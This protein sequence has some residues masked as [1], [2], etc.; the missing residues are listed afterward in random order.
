MSEQSPI[1]VEAP[2][3]IV[4]NSETEG[5]HNDEHSSSSASGDG[6]PGSEEGS[7]SGDGSAQS[8]GDGILE[9]GSEQI[10][11]AAIEAER[12][13]ALAEIHSDVERERIELERD[14]LETRNEDIAE[15]RREVERLTALVDSLMETVNLLTPPPILELVTEELPTVP[16][17]D[18][19]QPS[20]AAPTV[21][22]LT[23]LSEESA[24]ERQEEVIPNRVRRFIAI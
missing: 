5:N 1:T 15:C 22:T 8:N 4:S 14:A 12:D 18:L 23:E 7:N 19:T 24:E 17:C 11:V 10:A 13:V 6:L 3:V 20:T 21:E 9:P 2:T 16:E